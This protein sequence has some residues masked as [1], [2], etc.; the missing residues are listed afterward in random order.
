VRKA[1]LRGRWTDT[2]ALPGFLADV[3]AFLERGRL[4]RSLDLRGAEIGTDPPLPDF[5]LVGKEFSGRLSRL[6]SPSCRLRRAEP[7]LE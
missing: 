4:D 7:L 1:E 2:A 5:R 3:A 6:A